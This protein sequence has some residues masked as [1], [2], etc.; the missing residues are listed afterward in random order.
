MSDN[1]FVISNQYSESNAD[2]VESLPEL[3]D[4]TESQPEN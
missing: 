2:L 1:R 4:R 3:G